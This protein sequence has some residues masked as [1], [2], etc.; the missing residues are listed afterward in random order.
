MGYINSKELWGN[1]LNWLFSKW[2]IKHYLEISNVS[3]HGLSLKSEIYETYL[4]N[5]LENNIM[6]KFVC[7]WAGLNGKFYN[8]HGI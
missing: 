1:N 3:I 4:I 7:P 6:F 2:R 8:L 5:F